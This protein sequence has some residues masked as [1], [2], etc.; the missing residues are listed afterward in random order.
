MSTDNGR[1]KTE[2]GS[3]KAEAIDFRL[4]NVPELR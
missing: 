1:R 3:R 2:D 4:I